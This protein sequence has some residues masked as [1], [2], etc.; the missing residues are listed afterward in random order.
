MRRGRPGRGK[1]APQAWTW[2]RL[3]LEIDG[4]DGFRFVNRSGRKISG[5]YLP[6]ELTPEQLTLY[7]LIDDPTGAPF[8]VMQTYSV[9]GMVGA[10][11]MAE[12]GDEIEKRAKAKEQGDPAA[13][14]EVIEVDL[15]GSYKPVGQ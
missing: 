4:D 1:S 9:S 10:S 8:A 6:N 14:S 11:E 3:R 5:M 7:V 2:K 12:M 15:R 13:S